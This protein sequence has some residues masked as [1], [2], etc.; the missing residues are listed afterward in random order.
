[1][2]AQVTAARR[3][4]TLSDDRGKKAAASKIE[5]PSVAGVKHEQVLANGLSIH[6]ARAGVSKDK[7]LLLLI[8]GWPECDLPMAPLF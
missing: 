6:V 3:R 8:H 7:E 2:V 5:H 1:M 4:S